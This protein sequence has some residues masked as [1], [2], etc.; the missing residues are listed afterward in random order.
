MRIRAA[1][2]TV[3]GTASFIAWAVADGRACHA[4]RGGRLRLLAGGSE[5][6]DGCGRLR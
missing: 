2:C 4:R 6:F 1:R 5:G 3:G